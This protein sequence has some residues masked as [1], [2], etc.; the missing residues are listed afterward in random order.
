M[1][2]GEDT[3]D[4]ASYTRQLSRQFQSASRPPPREFT[5]SVVVFDLRLTAGSQQANSLHLKYHTRQFAVDLIA[6]VLAPQ[7]SC[8]SRFM[9]D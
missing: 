4:S 1:S 5:L 6:R 9:T 7:N 8:L 3:A 2:K